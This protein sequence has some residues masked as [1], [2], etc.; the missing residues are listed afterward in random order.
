MQDIEEV[1]TG[2]R[3]KEL[4][5][6]QATAERVVE[7]AGEA[8][9]EY[10]A[11]D[12]KAK[13]ELLAREAAERE[14]A[15]A[16]KASGDGEPAE[17]DP[18]A[19]PS[20]PLAAPSDPLAPPNE[21]SDSTGSDASAEPTEPSVGG[22]VSEQNHSD[23]SDDSTNSNAESEARSSAPLHDETVSDHQAPV[24]PTTADST[25]A[26]RCARP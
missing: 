17:S 12:E 8:S 23:A 26:S 25:A 13:V 18:L 10:A 11:E 9:K 16:A 20:D 2:P 7:R 5:L 21:S 24:R 15:A 1:G 22:D 19:P 3:V 4:E 6:D 14:A